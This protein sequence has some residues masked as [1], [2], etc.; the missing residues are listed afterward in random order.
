M[1]PC[2][3]QYVPNYYDFLVQSLTPIPLP[4]SPHTFLYCLLLLKYGI[5]VYLFAGTNES[6]AKS[7]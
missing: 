4:L 2:V 5:G 3:A 7:K 6:R 1:R